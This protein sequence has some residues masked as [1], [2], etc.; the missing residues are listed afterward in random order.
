MGSTQTE[1]SLG[2]SF[3][4]QGK[5]SGQKGDKTKHGHAAVELF[6]PFVE[7]PAVFDSYDFHAGFG[8]KSIKTATIFGGDG[9]AADDWGGGG[10]HGPF[11][12][13]VLLR[14]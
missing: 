9:G 13:E 14:L 10:G 6:S 8:G 7:T 3:A 11:P 2:E 4:T 5:F 1:Q 12:C